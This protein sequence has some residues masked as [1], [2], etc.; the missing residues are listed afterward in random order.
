MRQARSVW[1]AGIAAYGTSHELTPR[2]RQ[3]LAAIAASPEKV[4]R[5]TYSGDAI[6]TARVMQRYKLARFQLAGDVIHM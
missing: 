5:I 3:I 6:R 4:I 1:R 2:Q